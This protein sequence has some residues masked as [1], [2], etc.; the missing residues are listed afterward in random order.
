MPNSSPRLPR[1][2]RLVLA[3]LP[4]AT[5]PAAAEPMRLLLDSAHAAHH[6]PILAAVE[7]GHFA[8]Q[9]IEPAIES[10]LGAN[11]VAVMVG[12]RAF[13]LGHVTTAAAAGAISRGTPVRVVAVVQPQTALA[14]IG[15]ADKRNFD[16][17]RSI[18][19]LR[20]GLTPGTIDS[21]ALTLFR[22]ARNMGISALTVVP[23]DRSAKLAELVAGRVDVVIGDGLAMRA[24]LRA[25]GQEAA[26]LPLAERGVP[27]MG[28]GFIAPQTVITANP[29]LL[30]RALAAIRAGF[31]DAAA[32]PDGL[33][34]ELTP[35]Y[36]LA[37][38]AE[39]CADALR[40][41]LSSTTQ[42]GDPGPDSAKWG[43]QSPEA[44]Q[45]MIEAMRAGGEIQ[46]TRPPS[47]YYTNAVLP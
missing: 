17:A 27:L 23:T 31:A 47:F 40:L 42:P 11:M 1:V 44:W 20:V 12:Q 9:R 41:Y 18:E 5:A 37:E 35:R 29:D 26:V 36:R 32:D 45:R 28:F 19:G 24:A 21:M 14:F 30:R 10:G 39:D 7:R 6:A 25:Q 16:G 22:R 34:A 15:L 3:A 33:C 2:L 8:R 13:D 38:R 4:L 43:R 46:G